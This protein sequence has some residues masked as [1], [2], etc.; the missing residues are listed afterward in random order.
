MFRFTAAEQIKKKKESSLSLISV[1]REFDMEEIPD[2][3]RSSVQFGFIYM[4]QILNSSYVKVIYI[5][6][7]LQY[8]REDVDRWSFLSS[9]WQQWGGK[10]TRWEKR[11]KKG[12]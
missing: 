1:K 2:Y 3:L 4:V 12:A 6:K 9:S 5:V 11:Q 8:Y 7:I 10:T